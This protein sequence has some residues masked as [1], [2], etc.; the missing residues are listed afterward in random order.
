MSI[1]LIFAFCNCALAT[2]DESNADG[3]LICVNSFLK[4]QGNLLTFIRHTKDL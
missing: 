3:N 1:D 4:H 2:T